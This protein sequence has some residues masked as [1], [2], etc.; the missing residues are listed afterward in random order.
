M[1]GLGLGSYYQEFRRFQLYQPYPYFL[2]IYQNLSQA[3]TENLSALIKLYPHKKRVLVFIGQSPFE[4]LII[5]QV[6]NMGCTLKTMS[7]SDEINLNELQEFDPGVIVYAEDH[8][9]KGE[10]YHKLVNYAD[11]FKRVGLLSWS[12]FIQATNSTQFS[13]H[14]RII[15]KHV[16]R[17][18]AYCSERIETQPGGMIYDFWSM[19][20]YPE[21][22]AKNSVDIT[23]IINELDRRQFK[24]WTSTQSESP[25]HLLVQY[26]GETHFLSENLKYFGPQIRLI[27]W[28]E[29]NLL[30]EECVWSGISLEE[31]NSGVWF[32]LEL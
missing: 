31:W 19:V 24:I 15:P 10:S 5:H 3:L 27:D 7:T 28:R 25:Y 9:L 1:M 20:N 12:H 26:L 30:P 22:N 13:Y 2:H 29:L 23:Q 17:Y 32:I 16:S 8:A 14:I 18:I 4:K 6:Q 11:Q 21:L